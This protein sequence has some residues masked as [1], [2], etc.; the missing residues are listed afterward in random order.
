[1]GKSIAAH[2]A[3]QDHVNRQNRQLLNGGV[4]N[5][6]VGDVQTRLEDRKR[7]LGA[8][9]VSSY[10]QVLLDSPNVLV[11]AVCCLLYDRLC[12]SGKFIDKA[13]L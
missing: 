11:G 13:L 4:V 6:L 3:E 10:F 7:R 12:I 2:I 5:C 1:V 8:N 9:G